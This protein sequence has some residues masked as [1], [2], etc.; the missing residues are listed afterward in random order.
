VGS[1]R[2]LLDTS[3]LFTLFEDEAGADRVEQVLQGEPVV[4]PWLVLMEATYI[5]MQEK[6]ENEADK[7]YALLKQ[8][9]CEILWEAN[10]PILLTAARLKAGFHLSFAD[11]VIA[12]FAIQQDAFLLHKDPEFSVLSDQ[13]KLENLPYKSA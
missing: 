8:L 6:G 12:A 1:N 13:V 4:I 10:E 9:P 11:A 5:V 3:A 7:R 2:Y